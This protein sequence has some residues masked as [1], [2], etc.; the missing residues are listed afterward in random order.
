M[1]HC[2]MQYNTAPLHTLICYGALDHV[3]LTH[4]AVHRV[5]SCRIMLPRSL[6]PTVSC[7]SWALRVGRGQP[8]R[9]TGALARQFRRSGTGNC[10]K[11]RGLGMGGSVAAVRNA[12]RM[13]ELHNTVRFPRCLCSRQVLSCMGWLPPFLTGTVQIQTGIPS[14][15]DAYRPKSQSIPLPTTLGRSKL[16]CT[17]IM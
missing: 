15:A 1:L 12:S 4:V 10:G 3:M 16:A 2:P 11:D 7:T 14:P 9:G 6:R 5:A 8:V 17:R 13:D